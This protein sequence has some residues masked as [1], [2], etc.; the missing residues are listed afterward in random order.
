[1]KNYIK[2]KLRQIVFL[3][4]KKNVT[5][6]TREVK[7][8]G[9]SK[10]CRYTN[11]DKALSSTNHHL[12][13]LKMLTRYIMILQ[14]QSLLFDHHVHLQLVHLNVICRLNQYLSHNVHLQRK[15]LNVICCLNI[16]L[17]H[18]AHLQRVHD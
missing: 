6:S 4:R 1:M 13:S 8:K 12:L 2:E 14:L 7:T 3:E 11:A 15:L 18:H 9:A 5:N 16:C 17:N 10:R